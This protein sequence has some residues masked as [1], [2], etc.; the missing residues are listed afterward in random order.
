MPT[1]WWRKLKNVFFSGTE[2]LGT[3]LLTQ[4]FLSLFIKSTYTAYAKA[5]EF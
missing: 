5:N 2:N 1:Q 3:P 4:D